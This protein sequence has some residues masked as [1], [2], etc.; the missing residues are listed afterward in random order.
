MTPRAAGGAPAHL[1]RDRDGRLVA[2]DRR[3]G[4]GDQLPV[5]A[6]PAPSRGRG[7]AR[8]RTADVG[9]PRPGPPARSSGNRPP[10]CVRARNRPSLCPTLPARL[11]WSAGSTSPKWWPAT[12]TV[13]DTVPAGRSHTTAISPAPVTRC[14]SSPA[15]KS[16]RPA[17]TPGHGGQVT[18]WLS[19]SG[20][21]A[22]QR[23]RPP[24]RCHQN[25]ARIG[26]VSI[27]GP[28]STRATTTA[29]ATI[30][31]A[32]PNTGAALVNAHTPVTAAAPRTATARRD[33]P[34][35][36]PVR[37]GGASW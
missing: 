30:I 14:S 2:G 16:S 29:N 31:T 19:G 24:R 33:R 27:A 21:L 7:I 23:P 17:N 13:A 5:G 22:C 8:R 36:I 1:H 32:T 25:R 18:V 34:I 15:A 28:P 4:G 26:T 6:A 9:P 10:G 20:S 35:S 3:R 11:S 37:S 12:V